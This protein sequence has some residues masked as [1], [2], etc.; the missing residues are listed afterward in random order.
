[1]HPKSCSELKGSQISSN[2]LQS[3]TI[4]FL[5]FPLIVAVVL[6]HT[7]LLAVNE[8]TK[9]TLESEEY[10]IYA[11]V[12][13]LFAQLICRTAVP[14]YF[15]ISGFLFFYKTEQF[16]LHTYKDKLK[17]RCRTLLI[18]YII[19]NI[20]FIIIYNVSG[21]IFPGSTDHFID[22][23]LSLHDWIGFL[24]G[25]ETNPMPINYPFWFIR[26]LIVAVILSP[27]V[28]LA[29][30]YAGVLLPVVLGTA[31]LL[32]FKSDIP[33]I[34]INTSFFFSLGAY[35][36]ISKKNFVD[37]IKPHYLKLGVAYA[38]ILA[39]AFMTRETDYSIYIKNIGIIFGLAFIIAITGKKIS[40][41]KWHT[42]KFLTEASFF[43][44]AYH[45]IALPIIRR[46]IEMVISL[47][48]DAVL[49]ATYFLWAII[50]ILL[51]IGLYYMLRQISPRITSILTGGR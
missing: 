25:N 15:I 11:A 46:A 37:F 40:S 1:M 2:L 32:N 3:K 47:D 43:V 6:I 20:L 50:A 24:W 27:I 5:R 19:W 45:A 49:T 41:N 48:N 21:L 23:N 10:P 18:P 51:G 17:K 30:R 9:Y 13:Y 39:I 38:L 42:N 33:G 36:S 29:I 12:A 31:W 44:F 26:D 14:I 7:Q 16:T 34:G 28:Y 4:S 8:I 35:F 22:F